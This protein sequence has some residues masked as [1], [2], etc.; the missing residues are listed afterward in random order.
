MDKTLNVALN[1]KTAGHELAV[2]ALASE[3]ARET[4]LRSAFYRMATA[5]SN[6]KDSHYRQQGDNLRR[7]LDSIEEHAKPIQKHD[8]AD[9]TD[10]DNG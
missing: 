6:S 9:G 10:N 8:S 3:I 1:E 4:E 5:L 2:S 7:Y